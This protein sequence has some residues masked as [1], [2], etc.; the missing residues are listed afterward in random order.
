VLAWLPDGSFRSVLNNPTVRGRRREQLIAAAAAGDK[1]DPAQA[2]LVRVVEY[3]IDNR[4]GGGEL[5]CLITT[6]TD[7]DFAAAAAMLQPRRP[8]GSDLQ[9]GRPRTPHPVRDGCA[10]P[11]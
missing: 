4:T 5:F 11:A 1:P 3:M 8:S 9:A 2:M 7:P 10:M 6:L